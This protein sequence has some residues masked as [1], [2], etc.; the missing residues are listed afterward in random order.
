MPKRS[1]Q[2]PALPLGD[3]PLGQRLAYIRKQKGYTQV[4]LA[5]KMGLVQT[6]ISDY[7]RGKLRPH[8]EMVARFALA[9]EVSADEII[10]LVRPNKTRGQSVNRRFL[11][12]LQQ[13]DKL[14]R[15]D[16]EALLRTIDT[17]LDRDRL[18][19]AGRSM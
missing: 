7:E 13:I 8:A 19:H 17:F 9:L 10:G 1:L 12:R 2:L 4:E 14:A 15:R 5:Q 16:Q 3:E 6:L 18:A 11:R